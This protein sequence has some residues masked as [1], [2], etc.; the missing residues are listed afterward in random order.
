MGPQIVHA[1]RR[2]WISFG[3]ALLVLTL[4]EGVARVGS[5][6]RQREEFAAESEEIAGL[7]KAD[8][9]TGPDWSRDYA[10]ELRDSLR[11]V[12]RPYVYWRMPPRRGRYINVDS[13][14]I[15]HTWNSTTSPSPGQLKIFMF[16]GSTLWGVAARDD[17]TIPSLVSKKLTNHLGSGVW[18]TNF[19]Q[20]GYV[21]TQEVIT[22]MLELQRGNRPDVVVFYDGVNDIIAA[23]QSGVAGV[24]QNEVNRVAEFNSPRDLRPIILRRLALYRLSQLIVRSFRERVGSPPGRS[25]APD[26]ALANDVIDVYLRNVSLVDAMANRFGFKAVFFWQP[27]AFTKRVLSQ[28]EKDLLERRLIR[29]GR[30]QGSRLAPFFD[31]VSKVFD[32]K[33]TSRNLEKGNIYDLSAVLDEEVGTIFIDPFHVMES[34]NARIAAAMAQALQSTALRAKK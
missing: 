5:A 27:T 8:S 2:I 20:I 22:L 11:S 34:G 1:I 30:L 29:I 7:L 17:F 13:E 10:Q 33:V 28:E 4:L 16:G 9:S 14:G 23:W 15:R 21:T 3:V 19:G 31:Q 26:K 18:V 25:T 12:W 6:T 32:Q 24:P